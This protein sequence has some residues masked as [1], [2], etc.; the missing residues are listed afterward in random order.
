MTPGARVAAAIDILDAI[1]DGVA[2]EQALTR[3]SRAS[4]FAGSKDRA[5]VRDHVFDALRHWRSDAVRG[6]GSSGRARMIGRCRAAS[7]DPDTL[8]TGQGHAPATLSSAERTAGQRPKVVADLWDMQPWLVPLF[9]ASLG[10]DAERTALAL[11]HRAPVCLRVNVAKT[12]PAAAQEALKAHGVLTESNPRSDTALT[13]VQ[14]ARQVRMSKPFQ[15]GLVELQDASSQAAVQDL[16]GPGRALDFCAGGGG[17]TL[18]LA[19]LGWDVTAHDID[20]RRMAD[21]PYRAD[22]GGHRVTMRQGEEL[23]DAGPYDL[24]LVDAPCSGSGTW[25]RTPEAKWAL[26]QAR[27]DELMAMQRSVL[28]QAAD[29]VRSGGLL[30]YATCSVLRCENVEQIEIFAGRSSPFDIVRTQSWSVASQGDGFFAA[31]LTKRE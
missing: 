18:A 13:V 16:P 6:G 2:A 15:T 25:R 30:V 4:R 21:L 14:G 27:L 20:P 28:Q 24:V 22:R 8:F 26:T 1:A 17:K 19:A 5:A 7:I 23:H 3:W 29:L 12:N 11:T 9:Q 10:D 31:Y